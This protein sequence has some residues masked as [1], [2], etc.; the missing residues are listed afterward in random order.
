M[1]LHLLLTT[2]AAVA[3][4]GLLQDDESSGAWPP[5]HDIPQED[6][7]RSLESM[8]AEWGDRATWLDRRER[9]TTHLRRTLGLDRLPEPDAL[10]PSIHGTI[11]CEDYL[12]SSFHVETFPGFFA[13]GNIY[14]PRDHEGSLPIVLCPHGHARADATRPEGRFRADYQRLCATLAR[15]GA[16]VVTWDMVGWGEQDQVTHRRPESTS[17]QTFNTMRM[18]DLATGLPGA[19]GDRIGITGSSGGGTQTFLA[20]ALDERIDV[21]IP[22]VMVSAHFF[23]GCSCES[24]LPVHDGPD[25]RTNNVEFAAC[26][27][28]RPTMLISVGGDW[29]LNTP[30]VEFPY[31]KSVYAELDVPQRC[32]NVHLVEEDHDY[33]RNKRAPAYRFLARHLDLDIDRVTSEDGSIDETPVT[34]Q[35]RDALLAYTAEHPRPAHALLGDEAVDAAWEAYLHPPDKP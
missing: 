18:I 13:S 34:I 15:M 9:I 20:T 35:P 16:I 26:A 21:S 1:H 33:G 4:M 10:E 31:L 28:P 29:T 17:L 24:G 22:V 7:A 27:A 5:S 23:G 3:G 6:G 11:P 12:V 32:A 30:Q 25:F 2:V 8:R 14:R 19:D